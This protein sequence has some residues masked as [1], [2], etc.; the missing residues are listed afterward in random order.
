L[1]RQ[2]L[3]KELKKA[4]A[5]E[6]QFMREERQRLEEKRIEEARKKDAEKKKA[7]PRWTK[8]YSTFK[9]GENKEITRSKNFCWD[10]YQTT[11]WY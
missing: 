3:I 5:K 10:P 11:H 8:T 9:R 1:D 2:N 6:E 7:Y 4:R